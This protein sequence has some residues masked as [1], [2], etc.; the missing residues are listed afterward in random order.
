[1]PLVLNSLKP[2]LTKSSG[3]KA[4]QIS[5]LFV[6]FWGLQTVQRKKSIPIITHHVRLTNQHKTILFSYSIAA[7]EQNQKTVHRKGAPKVNCSTAVSFLLWFSPDFITSPLHYDKTT[8]LVY[9]K[10]LKRLPECLFL[11]LF[12]SEKK[13]S[14]KEL[15]Q[16]TEGNNVLYHCL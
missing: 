2:Q 7:S 3:N 10:I 15:R 14:P 13:N 16:R 4:R 11:S 1:M 6:I 12:S 8:L 9:L 5:L